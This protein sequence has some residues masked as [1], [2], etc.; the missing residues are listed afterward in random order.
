METKDA[1]TITITITTTIYLI[2]CL[3][4]FVWLSLLLLQEDE[5]EEE[6]IDGADVV[7]NRSIRKALRQW[8]KNSKYQ[9][10]DEYFKARPTKKSLGLQGNYR[11]LRTFS[12]RRVSASDPKDLSSAYAKQFLPLVTLQPPH[13]DDVP[14][15]V[16]ENCCCEAAKS[17]EREAVLEEASIS[18]IDMKKRAKLIAKRRQGLLHTAFGMFKGKG[19]DSETNGGV[20]GD[21]D[22]SFN[23]LVNNYRDE[24]ADL[25]APLGG[26]VGVASMFA[27]AKQFAADS[28]D[29]IP[30]ANG[31]NNGGDGQAGSESGGK[32]GAEGQDGGDSGKS[33]SSG[34]GQLDDEA[35][36]AAWDK[37]LEELAAQLEQM[38]VDRVAANQV[39]EEMKMSIKVCDTY[40]FLFCF[41]LFYFFCLFFCF[42]LFYFVAWCFL[43]SVHLAF[44]CCDIGQGSCRCW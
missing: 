42:V 11:N 5:E 8:S 9:L 14:A 24:N 33:G 43:G 21:F 12:L 1:Q 34:A 30:T 40:P 28:D 3:P 27:A 4:L 32:S 44:A 25:N 2:A 15:S 36:A 41:I 16:L 26:G 22:L 18:G 19:G 23:D 31:D 29:P 7:L 10:D 17:S 38:E 20:S 37:E 39:G 6:N 13:S 35:Q